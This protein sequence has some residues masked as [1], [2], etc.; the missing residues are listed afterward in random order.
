MTFGLQDDVWLSPFYRCWLVH[1][2]ILELSVCSGLCRHVRKR[3][4]DCLGSGS[5]VGLHG[6]VLRWEDGEGRSIIHQHPLHKLG[7]IPPR[8]DTEQACSGFRIQADIIKVSQGAAQKIHIARQLLES[9]GVVFLS[10]LE[11]M[12]Q[13]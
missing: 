10:H 3:G 8:T 1:S 11:N 13:Q 5:G 12:S 4:D 2:S 7:E 9:W 6:E